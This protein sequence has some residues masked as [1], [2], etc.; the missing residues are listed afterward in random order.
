MGKKDGRKRERTAD[1]LYLMHASEGASSAAVARVASA[2]LTRKTKR[3]CRSVSEQTDQRRRR[4]GEAMEVEKEVMGGSR[5]G[6]EVAGEERNERGKADKEGRMYQRVSLPFLCPFSI[7]YVTV[8]SGSPPYTVDCNLPVPA[9]VPHCFQL[10]LSSTQRYPGA[11]ELE[12]ECVVQ[13]GPRASTARRLD[14]KKHREDVLQDT[15]LA[16]RRP[17]SRAKREIRRNGDVGWE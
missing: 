7:P 16:R 2:S 11:E 3:A 5:G 17:V 13:D 8:A 10:R 12:L 14:D 6:R 15:G 4:G 9:P 1:L